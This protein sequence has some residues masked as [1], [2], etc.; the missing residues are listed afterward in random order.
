MVN[1]KHIQGEHTKCPHFKVHISLISDKTL[2]AN[3]VCGAFE[4]VDEKTRKAAMEIN[5][6]L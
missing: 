3:M 6:T 1:I 4:L 2:P 5:F